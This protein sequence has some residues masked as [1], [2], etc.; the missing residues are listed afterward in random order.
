MKREDYLD[1]A[2]TEAFSP[3][4]WRDVISEFV[5]TAMLV[6]VQC[7]VPL[8]HGHAGYGSPVE[9]GLAVGFIV[10]TMGWTMDEFGGGHMNPAVTFSMAVCLRVTFVRGTCII[11]C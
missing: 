2:R 8:T 6:T 5:A 4:F 11:V 7:F 9:V 1:V 3:L 10:C